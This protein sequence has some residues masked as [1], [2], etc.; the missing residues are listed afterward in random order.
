MTADT[1]ADT[2]LQQQVSGQAGQGGAGGKKWAKG[3]SKTPPVGG[4]ENYSPQL[5]L[6]LIGKFWETFLL[7]YFQKRGR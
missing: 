6:F 3:K 1:F 5:C 2:F 7:A 4:G